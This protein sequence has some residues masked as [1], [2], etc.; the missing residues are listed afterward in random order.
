MRRSE[1][2]VEQFEQPSPM[3]AVPPCSLQ[4]SRS[5]IASRRS[6]I[7][8]PVLRKKKIATV[9]KALAATGDQIVEGHCCP[10]ATVAERLPAGSPSRT[11][12]SQARAAKRDPGSGTLPGIRFTDAVPASWWRAAESGHGTF[13]PHHRQLCGWAFSL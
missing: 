2:T 13:L 8:L 3:I 5:L 12:L 6:M 7:L 1:G 10:M 4:G 11:H 9:F